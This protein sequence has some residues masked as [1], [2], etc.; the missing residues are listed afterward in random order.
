L[1]HEVKKTKFYV[2]IATFAGVALSIVLM[3][4]LQQYAYPQSNILT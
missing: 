2:Y 1:N 4:K 3:L